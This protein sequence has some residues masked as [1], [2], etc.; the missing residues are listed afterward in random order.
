MLNALLTGE[1]GGINMDETTLLMGYKNHHNDRNTIN[2]ST[3]LS[4]YVFATIEIATT[5]FIIWY[6]WT[7]N[8]PKVLKN[9]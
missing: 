9:E 7:W 3:Q 4:L 8:N 1:V 2:G 6:A 5:L